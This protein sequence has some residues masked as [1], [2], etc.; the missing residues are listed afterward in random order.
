MKPPLVLQ[1]NL[2]LELQALICITCLKRNLRSRDIRIGTKMRLNWTHRDHMTNSS[3]SNNSQSKL[4]S[5]LLQ[6]IKAD[7]RKFIINSSYRL[8]HS[9]TCKLCSIILLISKQKGDKT[10]Y[11]VRR[12]SLWTPIL[13]KLRMYLSMKWSKTR[14]WIELM[15]VKLSLRIKGKWDR[16]IFRSLKQLQALRASK[17]RSSCIPLS[18]RL[19]MPLNKVQ[20]LIMGSKVLDILTDLK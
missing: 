13:T 11:P 1:L 15:R 2:K 16:L 14:P 20:C 3:N 9:Q 4:F 19:L 5:K 8:G 18:R 10:P 6:E 12:E 17:R 7:R